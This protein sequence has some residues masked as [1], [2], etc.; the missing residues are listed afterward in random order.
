MNGWYSPRCENAGRD[1]EFR[2]HRDRPPPARP[3]QNYDQEVAQLGTSA[4]KQAPGSFLLLDSDSASA[5]T[6]VLASALRVVRLVT[7]SFSLLGIREPD[8]ECVY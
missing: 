8:Q 1:V 4:G 2:H 5:S 3:S 7:R 6:A